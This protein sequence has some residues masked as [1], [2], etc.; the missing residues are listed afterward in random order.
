MDGQEAQ[1]WQAIGALVYDMDMIAGLWAA[2]CCKSLRGL[3]EKELT[4]YLTCAAHELF[5]SW[6]MPSL[7]ITRMYMG[8]TWF[9][10]DLGGL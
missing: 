4:A 3:G 5:E 10:I 2:E 1:H 6:E 7:N 8:E 9:V